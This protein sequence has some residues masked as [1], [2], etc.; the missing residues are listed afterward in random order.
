MALTTGTTIGPYEIVA[1]L[2]AGGMGEVYHARDT[3]LDRSVAV[4][5]MPA[6]FADD[7]ERLQR[8][9]RE[10]KM[11]AAL[12]H[13]NVGAIYGLEEAD[14][15]RFL[16]LE[17][18]D[19]E[20]L[21]QRI[22]RGTVPIRETLEIGQQIGSAIAV[23]HERGIVHRDLKPGNVM[24]TKERAVKVLDF[25]LA[26]EDMSIADSGPALSATPTRVHT[27]T[28]Q[29]VILGTAPYMSPEQA[30]GKPVDTRTDVWALGC[31]LFECLTGRQTFAGE[32]A[33]DVIARI[34]EREP[35]WD[36]LPDA[37][38]ERLRDTIASCLT[39]DVEQRPG[40]IGAI[41]KELGA[42]ALDLTNESRKPASKAAKTPSLAVL[43]FENQTNDSESEYFCSGITEDILTDL[44]KIKNLRVASRNAVL[45][46]RGQAAEIEQIAKDLKVDAVLEG[47]VR[48]AGERVRITA[49][50]INGA[51]GFQLW[52]ERYD[53]TLQDVFAVQEEIA[54]AITEAL[55]VAMTP[56]E[57]ENLVKD[58][59]KD[60]RAYD[61]YLRGRQEYDKYTAKGFQQAIELF[62]QAIEIDPNYALA[63]AGLGD[64]YGQIG[65]WGE[66]DNPEEMERLGLESANRAIELNPKLPEGYKALALVQRFAGDLETARVTLAKALDAD[67]RFTPALINLAVDRFATGDLSANERL[68][69]RAIEVDPQHAFTLAW[70]GFLLGFTQRHR[71]VPEV[72][73]QMRRAS[74]DSFILT[75]AALL[76]SQAL[77][78][79]GDVDGA[80]KVLRDALEAGGEPANIRC[81]LALVAMHQ[82]RT[83]EARE[84]VDSMKDQRGLGAGGL[85]MLCSAA[86]RL[87]EPEKAV[88]FM[89]RSLVRDMA[90]VIIRLVPDLHPMAS[91]EP[92][93]PRRL[94]VRLIWPLEA[95]M[96]DPATF[97]LFREVQIESGKPKGSDV[98]VG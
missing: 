79:L 67:P 1:P 43:Y 37:I 73:E 59:P 36:E 98:Q 21:S 91:I 53:R 89:S 69:L 61:L 85:M 38:P 42:I 62:N 4:K 65:Q 39:K 74:S 49:Q 84:I 41:G 52:A 16:V 33:S 47:S 66:V 56:A 55:R 35:A 32:T 6:A 27:A 23:A 28:G 57:T 40:D 11:L 34:L 15:Q 97:N 12:N 58:R 13:P 30:R 44:S 90:S 50:L 3:R 24:L 5:S 22:T 29:G 82:G 87:G 75:G 18:I 94:D 72:T 78:Q 25:G 95:P 7:S 96:I 77:I 64:A 86:C 54:S 60:A 8:F 45:K 68:V 17:F 76:E 31:I 63:Y 88:P 19:G 20:T 9:E 48:R 51:D 93:E 80:N 2:G 26:K 70:R 71:E 46:Y 92:F 14:G 83:D 10:A 81:G